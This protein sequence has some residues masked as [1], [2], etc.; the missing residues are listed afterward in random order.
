VN[1]ARASKVISA[2]YAHPKFPLTRLR[3]VVQ[4]AQYGISELASTEATGL[5]IIRMN[6]LQ[7]DGWDFSDLKYIEL[8]PRD[9]ARYLLEPG[10]ILFN[11]TNSKELVGKCEVFREAGA[12]VFAS[13]LIRVRL[14]TN[15]ALPDFVSLFLN[16]TAGRAQIDRISRQIIGMSNVNAE[17]LQDM[18]IPLAPLDIQRAFV[19]QMQAAREVR[20]ERLQRANALLASLDAYL[21]DTLNITLPAETSRTIFAISLRQIEGALNPERYAGL[22]F[23]KCIADPRMDSVARILDAKVS[24]AKIAP[25]EEWDRIR[26]D[27]LPNQPLGVETLR[28]VLGSELEEAYFE[29][30]ENDILLAR[31]GPTIQNAK[32]V[33]CPPLRRRTVASGEFLV[34]R[35]REGWNPVTVLAVLR[36]KALSR[37][38]VFEM[39][40]RDT[41]PL[42]SQR[43]RPR[44]ASFSKH[45]RGGAAANR[46]RSARAQRG[47]AASAH[48]GGSRLGGG[49]GAI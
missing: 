48:R 15:A 7:A 6:N 17:E 31:L 41:Q 42:P 13:Y 43:R 38:H 19:A 9:A 47:S 33:L 25:A 21:L 49:K 29:V 35:C 1:Y 5:P 12:W 39:S 27:D 14:D 28:S 18:V 8:S 23:A 36:T 32:F 22:L 26:I 3:K 40:R 45:Q 24:P 11:R 30:Q 4:F 2:L 37:H 34:L 10:D 20:D 46:R 44:R 16:T